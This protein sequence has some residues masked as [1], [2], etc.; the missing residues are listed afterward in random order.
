MKLF[1]SWQSDTPG[2]TGRLFI[3][4]ALVAAVEY[5]RETAEILEPTEH[6]VRDGRSANPAGAGPDPLTT[7]LD[8][9][10]NVSV[11]VADVSTVGLVPADPRAGPSQ[12]RPKRLISSDVAVELGYAT[13][14]LP[15]GALLLV[16]NTYYGDEKGLPPNLQHGASPLIFTL[17]PNAKTEH[18]DREF[19]NLKVQFIDA[20]QP[21]VAVAEKRDP[22]IPEL[23]EFEAIQPIYSPATF[24]SRY[25]TLASAG[26][27]GERQFNCPSTRVGYLRFYPEFAPANFDSE[28]VAAVFDKRIPFPMSLS[29]G[30]TFGSNEHGRIA[31]EYEGAALITA[32]TQGF[33]SGEIWG[34]TA[35]LFTRQAVRWLAT[36]QRR[37]QVVVQTIT[38]EKV[39]LRTLRNYVQVAAAL[40]FSPPYTVIVGAV[41]MKDI[42]LAVPGGPF[43][44]GELAGPVVQDAFRQKHMLDSAD[45]DAIKNLLRRVF[46]SFYSLVNRRREDTLT[47]QLVAA[48]DLPPR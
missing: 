9:I 35:Q 15:H 1:W 10:D 34:V 20:L 6:D 17:A 18:R 36:D 8:R 24:F 14:A 48:H 11:F 46:I 25:E 38:M 43:S 44:N 30:G 12:A 45:D 37:M 26:E 31:F 19:L 3:R 39:Y 7:I 2:A 33:P 29:Y 47:D 21:F 22:E 4:N 13:G 40:G 32:L 41:G 28:K 42:Y 27:S 5:M 16:M 23:L